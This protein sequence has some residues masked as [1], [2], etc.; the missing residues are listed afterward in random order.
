MKT[1]FFTSV[2]ALALA[3]GSAHAQDLVFPI[4]EGGFNWDS[5][6]SFAA[7]HDYTGETITISGPWIG[8]DLD[9]VTSML[10][11]FEE[12]TGATVEYSGSDSFESEIRRAAQ[13]GGLPNIAVIPQPG[14]MADLA[15]QGD[16]APLSEETAGWIVENY[17]AGQSWVDLA[18][19]YNE[20]AGEEAL[21]GFFYK[22]DVKS[23]VWYS[24]PV[25]EELGYEIPTTMEELV[26]LSEQAIA[27]G[28]T[29]WCIGIGSEGAT[30][31]PATD[32]V[33]DIM[34]RTQP[35]EVYDQWVSN[36]IPFDDERVV[37]A[38]E[39]FGSF[40]RNE[41]F[42][43]MT[44]AE[45]VSNDFRDAPDGLFEI[46]PQCLMHRQ[47]SFIPTFFPE[48]AEFD[49]FYFPPFEE[50][51]LG[52]PV[53]GAGTAW[54]ITQD[55]DATRGMIDWLKTPIAHELWMAQSGFLTPHTGVDTELYGDETLRG[56][57]EILLGATSFRFDASDLM[58]S[59]IGAGA[60]WTGMVEYMRTGD[61]AE[62]AASIQDSWDAIQ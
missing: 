42:T 62:E 36:E 11:Y 49:F 13:T 2:A 57:G 61:A 48:G 16:I 20:Q 35:L 4:G 12:A 58:P 53:L 6:E 45:I 44:P 22:V 60:F 40:A 8:D 39:V 17:A 34:L 37:N 29:P 54:S 33:E 47:A 32:W 28:F 41:E 5:Y 25:F 52:S 24:P 55:S 51:D 31:W 23:L 1:R 21:N 7:E 27:D 3:A 56:M 9:L 59:E 15:R 30:G 50:E 14:L 46:P 19:S 26:G 10:A 38:I 43:G 18:T